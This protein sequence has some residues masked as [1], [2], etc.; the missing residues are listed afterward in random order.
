[1]KI[2]IRCF[3]LIA[4][5]GATTVSTAYAAPASAHLPI[6]SMSGKKPRTIKFSLR[7]DTGAV[8]ELKVGDNPVTLEAGKLLDV[9]LPLGTRIITNTATTAHP[10]GDV[11][12]EVSDRYK[13]SILAISN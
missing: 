10:I 1:M 5:I 4:V 6:A 2:I 12:V 7:N 8:L 9:N 3:V 11:I 13:D